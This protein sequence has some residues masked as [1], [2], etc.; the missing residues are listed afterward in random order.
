VRHVVETMLKRHGYQV[1]SSASVSDALGLAERLDGALDLLITDVVMPGMSGR[2]MAECMLANRPGMKVLYVS[3]YG[4]SIDSE[5]AFL[6]KPFTT[7][8]LALKI[9]EVLRNTE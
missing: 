7:D 9:R 2:K 8:E 5:D 6:Q 4:D 1:L 3:G